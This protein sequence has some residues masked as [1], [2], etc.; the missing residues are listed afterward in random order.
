MNYLASAVRRGRFSSTKESFCFSEAY[1]SQ[2]K[3][4]SSLSRSACCLYN[5]ILHPGLF[6]QLTCISTA[7]WLVNLVSAAGYWL[8]SNIRS[9]GRRIEQVFFYQLT[10]FLLFY[11]AWAL[12]DFYQMTYFSSHLLS[13]VAIGWNVQIAY[14]LYFVY[15]RFLGKLYRKQY[16]TMRLMA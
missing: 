6:Y 7:C 13:E 10:D 4:Q 5:E 9:S 1:S 14:F 8:G 3:L 12:T 16:W 11:W 2:P 15:R